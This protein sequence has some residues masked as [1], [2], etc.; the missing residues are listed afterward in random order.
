MKTLT[1]PLVVAAAAA[2]AACQTVPQ[3]DSELVGA[4]TAV[5]QARAD[6]YASRAGA[7]DLD[8][9]Q[10]S[11]QRAEAAWT[12]KDGEQ[13]NQEAYLARRRAEAALAEGQQARYDEQLQQ[14]N[15]ERERL[16][17]EAA[18][19][20]ERARQQAEAARREAARIAER[21]AA[22]QRDLQAR[23]T[24]RGLLAAP[25]E[26]HF[27]SGHARL[28]PQARRSAQ[29]IAAVLQQYPERRVRV[30]GHADSRGSE[31]SNMR[32]SQR[33]AEALRQALVKAGVDAGRIDV[34]A[35][36]ESMPAADNAT[37]TGRRQNR[38]VELLLSDGQGRF[39]TR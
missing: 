36:G 32:L 21:N 17:Q 30:E 2:L 8:R 4:R 25:A 34:Q 13:A 15:A 6:A 29:S 31:A 27:A 37:A 19:R 26:L 16:R 33:R 38:R 11:L 24:D 35:Y 9:A 18:A 12:A 14:A 20:D 3:N 39:N 10:Q 28:T 7:A 23:S 22:L 5:T 1:L